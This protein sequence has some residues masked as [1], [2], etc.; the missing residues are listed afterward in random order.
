MHHD[1]E[2]RIARIVRAGVPVVSRKGAAA[3]AHACSACIV[4]RAAEAVLT[5][6]QVVRVRTTG[7]TVARIVRAGVAVVAVE[8]CTRSAY[9]SAARILKRTDA[10]VV[11]WPFVGRE[12]AS[13]R[14]VTGIVGAGVVVCANYREAWHARAVP[15]H[16]A[17]RTEAFVVA[18]GGVA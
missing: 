17:G 11:A 13:S 18:D 16:I 15:A 9:A 2:D 4:G 12:D 5:G 7:R 6:C 10:A 1:A 3:D 14:W 8:Q